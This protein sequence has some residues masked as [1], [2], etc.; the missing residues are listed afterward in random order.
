MFRINLKC[1]IATVSVIVGVLAAPGPA[2]AS[3][4]PLQSSTFM[5][6]IDD[7]LLDSGRASGLKFE[8]EIT[9]YLQRRTASDL[10]R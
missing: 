6:Y 2:S 3:S 10:T 5:D 4:T 8:T 1:S 9:D 7:A